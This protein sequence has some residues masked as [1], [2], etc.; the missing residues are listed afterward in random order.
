V[1]II[2][3]AEVTSQNSVVDYYTGVFGSK[4]KG[5]ANYY[6]GDTKAT[7]WPYVCALSIDKNKGSTNPAYTAAKILSDELTGKNI[8]L[9]G[10]IISGITPESSKEVSKFSR[11]LSDV[12]INMNKVSDNQ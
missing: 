3:P 6:Q 4:D 2:F 10:I 5:L 7:Y 9:D 12:I 1:K 8:K 11:T